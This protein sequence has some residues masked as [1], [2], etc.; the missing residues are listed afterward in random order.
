MQDK[1]N[2][3]TSDRVV[4]S[5]FVN[6]KFLQAIFW[7]TK[8]TV[9]RLKTLMFTLLLITPYTKIMVGVVFA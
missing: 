7:V 2:Y 3:I 8:E 9:N 6:L 5:Y 4:N 1:F